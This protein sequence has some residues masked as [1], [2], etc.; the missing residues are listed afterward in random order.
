[1]III[2]IYNTVFLYRLGYFY[3]VYSNTLSRFGYYIKFI[4]ISR[5]ATQMATIVSVEVNISFTINSVDCRIIGLCDW[6]RC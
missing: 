3:K 5:S 2:R 6:I 4:Q 1:M